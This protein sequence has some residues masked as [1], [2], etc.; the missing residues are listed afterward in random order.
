L[1]P[2]LAIPGV[3][4]AEVHRGM[5]IA[6]CPQPYCLTAI[7]LP[8]GSL[9]MRC[10]GD[11]DACGAEAPVMWPRDPEAIAA[12]L[13]MRPVPASR[14]WLPHE[15]LQDLL[16]ENAEHGLLPAEWTQ[17]EGRTLILH[18]VE[19]MAMAGLLADSLPPAASRL[20]LTGVAG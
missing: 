4:H 20:M 1:R 14:N 3:A 11:R 6:R 13:R 17:L 16:T 2:D 9:V 8:L 15:S 5:W 19:G 18:E 7:A 10:H 12:L